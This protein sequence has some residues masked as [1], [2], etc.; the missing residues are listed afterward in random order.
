MMTPLTDPRG[1]AAWSVTPSI[2]GSLL[3]AGASAT[4]TV[5]VPGAKAGMPVITQP[6]TFPGA[7][8]SWDGYVSADDTV[9]V[10]VTAII[11]ATPTA[12]TYNVLVII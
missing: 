2:G 12:S 6:N 8:I 11:A 1:G 9:T 7:G 4:D 10:R 5:S 3:A